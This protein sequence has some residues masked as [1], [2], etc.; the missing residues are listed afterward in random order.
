MTSR[1]PALGDGRLMY[2]RTM[3]GNTE[4]AAV[5]SDAEVGPRASAS[6]DRPRRSARASARVGRAA[7][8]VQPPVRAVPDARP[9]AG[10]GLLWALALFA[11]LLAGPAVLAAVVAP[12]AFVATAS[13]LRSARSAPGARQRRTP[14]AATAA[15]PDAATPATTAPSPVAIAVAVSVAVALVALAALGGPIPAVLVGLAALGV[16]VMVS[17]SLGVPAVRAA[18]V[19]AA[20]A[21]AAGSVVL[22]RRQGLAVGL[23]LVASTCLFDAASCLMGNGLTGGVLGTVAGLATVTALGF[24]VAAIAVPPFQGST[25]W[26]LTLVTGALASLGVH[27]GARLVGTGRSPALRRLDSLMVSGPVWV[28]AVA[29]VLHK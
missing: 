23:V 11:A 8:R 2:G 28:I 13:M 25:P 3:Y 12:V 15:T 7:G 26:V 29:L 17:G 10:L 6:A 4:G 21:A 5:G 18:L 22:A 9:L 27:L 20:P 24:L 14:A 16:A 19:T 1:A